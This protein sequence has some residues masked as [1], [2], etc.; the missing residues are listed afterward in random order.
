MSNGRSIRG[1]RWSAPKVSP[2]PA[3]R[4]KDITK[5]TF[6]WFVIFGAVALGILILSA[7]FGPDDP[8]P[9]QPPAKCYHNGLEVPCSH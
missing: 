6:W 4:A 1:A 9:Y 7:I 2:G 8:E 5:A 3:G